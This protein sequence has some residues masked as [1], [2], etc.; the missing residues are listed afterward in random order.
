MSRKYLNWK[1][2]NDRVVRFGNILLECRL[3]VIKGYLIIWENVFWFDSLF[4]ED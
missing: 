1:L 4:I 2:G 3:T